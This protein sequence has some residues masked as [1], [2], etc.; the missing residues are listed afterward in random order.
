[1][2]EKPFDSAQGKPHYAAALKLPELRAFI[3]GVGF[4]S[5]AGRAV[6]VVIGFQIWKMTHSAAM[7]GWLGLVEAVPAISLVLFGGYIAD[8]FRRKNILL[9]TRAVSV[10][11]GIA[12]TALS[13]NAVDS[14]FPFYAVIFIA[15][16]ARAFADPAATALESQLV[17]RHL[18]VNASSWISSTWITCSV[19]G[20]AAIGFVFDAK[21]AAFSYAVITALYAA[22]WTATLMLPDKPKPVQTT[23]EPIFKSIGEGWR[24]VMKSQA[25][26]GA[27]SLDLLAVLFGG[28]VAL[29]PIFADQILHVGAKGLGLLNAAPSVGALIIT[30]AATHYA[31]IARAGRNLLWTVVGFGAS[32]LVFAF[33]RNFW[34]SM[35]ALFFSGVF[36]G[37]SVVIRRSMLRLLSPDHLRGRVAAANWIFISASNEIGAFES[38][39]VAAL[40]G[41]VPCVAV[42]GVLTLVVA[43]AAAVGFPELRRLRFD[44]HTLERV[45]QRE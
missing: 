29:L 7:L 45:A 37:V 11:C 43:G 5:L 31:P 6:L 16:F 15:G 27:M 38:G 35:T 40:I 8:H 17:P 30:L 20:P 24:F 19:A 12:L 14:V 39:M 2:T 9:I 26:L 1:M 33:S 32:I 28:A 41:T 21:G 13:L 25:L 36:D 34:L 23:R 18:T 10:A 3:A 42:G 44:E 4:F 22:A